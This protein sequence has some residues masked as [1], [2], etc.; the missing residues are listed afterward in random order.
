METPPTHRA[1]P[2]QQAATPTL[3]LSLA[4][5]AGLGVQELAAEHPASQVEE[6]MRLHPGRKWLR[7]SKVRATMQRHEP[8]RVA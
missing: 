2:S 1:R 8:S 6:R 5:V 7:R 4:L 3:P